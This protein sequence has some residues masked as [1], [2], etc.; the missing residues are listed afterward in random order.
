M[1]GAGVVGAGVVGAGVLQGHMRK[2]SVDGIPQLP[3][4][5]L[6]KTVILNSIPGKQAGAKSFSRLTVATS[7]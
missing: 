3:P 2:K 6:L 1:V 7:L 4:P 5:E